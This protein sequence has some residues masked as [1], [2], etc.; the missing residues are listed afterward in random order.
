MHIFNALPDG[1]DIR[2]LCA[3][4]SGGECPQG[5]LMTLGSRTFLRCQ[6]SPFNQAPQTIETKA[7][8][9]GHFLV[10]LKAGSGS[11]P[12]RSREVVLGPG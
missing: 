2:Y 3:G 8:R 4:Q 6:D 11:A 9:G 12:T 1:W 10:Y 5:S 7:G